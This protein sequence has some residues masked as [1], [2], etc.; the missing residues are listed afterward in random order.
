MKNFK[1]TLIWFTAFTLST[2]MIAIGVNLVHVYFLVD[3]GIASFVAG[4]VGFL[5]LYPAFTSWQDRFTDLFK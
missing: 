2:T 5:I 1:E 4:L 3:F